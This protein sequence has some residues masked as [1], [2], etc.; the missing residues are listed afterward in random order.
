M[1]RR[2]CLAFGVA[3][4]S[5]CCVDT[6]PHLLVCLLAH[7]PPQHKLKYDLEVVQPQY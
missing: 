3:R 6:M 5:R 4:A 7:V 2:E 1:G